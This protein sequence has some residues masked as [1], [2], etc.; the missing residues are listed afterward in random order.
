M[1]KITIVSIQKENDYDELKKVV[2]PNLIDDKVIYCLKKY[3]GRKCDTI[4]VEYPYYD[5]DYLSTYY[6]HYAQK[7]KQYSKNAV[8]CI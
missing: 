3:I 6:S 4:Q 5:S 1:I 8:V 7:F 2:P